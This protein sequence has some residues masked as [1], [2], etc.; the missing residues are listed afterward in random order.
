VR[1]ELPSHTWI[2]FYRAPELVAGGVAAGRD[3]LP[4]VRSVLAERVAAA[5]PVA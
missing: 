3:S 1:P 4:Q 2:E 5:R